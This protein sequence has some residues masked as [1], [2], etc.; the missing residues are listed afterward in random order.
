[1]T[2]YPGSLL[3]YLPGIHTW[4]AIGRVI[5]PLIEDS[6]EGPT[7]PQD[8]LPASSVPSV[9]RLSGGEHDTYGLPVS[10]R[11]MPLREP[12]KPHLSTRSLWHLARIYSLVDARKGL[13]D[14]NQQFFNELADLVCRLPVRRKYSPVV[15]TGTPSTPKKTHRFRRALGG[16]PLEHVSVPARRSD[17][18]TGVPVLLLNDQPV[19]FVKPL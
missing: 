19:A 7:S 5:S 18:W 11:R 17:R 13:R 15:M 10:L 1:M 4:V 9:H 6:T 8:D 14:R 2:T 16:I 12:V 3:N